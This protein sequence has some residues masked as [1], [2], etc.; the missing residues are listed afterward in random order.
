MEAVKA[1]QEKRCE[2]DNGV[3]GKITA[4]A[5]S[6]FSVYDLSLET[7]DTDASG[8]EQMTEFRETVLKK[9]DYTGNFKT[10]C[11]R[12]CA[13]TE[14]HQ[15]QKDGFG[16]IGPKVE[17]HRGKA[18]CGNDGGNLKEAVTDE[19]GK[20]FKASRKVETANC[21]CGGNDSDVDPKLRGTDRRFEMAD[22]HQVVQVEIDTEKEHSDRDDPL[23]C[24]GEGGCTVRSYAEAARAG[25]TKGVYQ[26]FKQIHTADLQ[27]DDQNHGHNQ[28]NEV[29]RLG[30]ILHSGE[31]LSHHRA[32]G[33]RADNMDGAV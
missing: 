23:L 33:F 12:A 16:Q 15:D 17:I 9:K 1:D 24:V 6:C 2:E 31:K 21:R 29:E 30:G 18:G 22:Q 10:A 26:T 25:G 4:D 14:E 19:I 5:L 13:G 8:M 11:S 20:A 3:N 7:N 28:I 27:G 32:G